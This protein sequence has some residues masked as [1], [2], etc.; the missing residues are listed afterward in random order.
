MPK[1]GYNQIA[2][3]R[4]RVNKIGR[5]RRQAC[6]GSRANVAE[7]RPLGKLHHLPSIIS[8]MWVPEL[9]TISLEFSGDDRANSGVAFTTELGDEEWVQ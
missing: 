2:E 4:R 5:L 3:I 6:R 1:I 8:I 7:S 9:A